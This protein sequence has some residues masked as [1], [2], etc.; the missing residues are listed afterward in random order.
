MT[1]KISSASNQFSL[2]VPAHRFRQGGRDVYFFALD[3]GT[4]DGLLPQ[5]VDDSVVRDANRRLTPSHAQSIQRYLDK[6]DDWVLGALL[7]GIARDA[8]E[9]EPYSGEQADQDGQ[10]ENPF[11][12]F[13]ELRV[14]TNR[15]NT[16]RIFD[17]QHRRR[18]IQEVLADLSNEHDNRSHDKLDA[19]RK[20]SMTIVLYVE[21]DIRTLRQ[22][23]VDASNTKR[24]E[25]NTVTRF[26]QRDAFNRVAVR[27]A[28]RSYLFRGRVEMERSSVS[29][30]SQNLMAINQ[31]AATL[32]STAVGYG[33]RVSRDLNEFYMQNLD[34][35]YSRCHVW[36]DEFMPAAREEYSGLL[37][38]QI[39]NSE[40]PQLRASTFA[41]SVTFFRVLASCYSR[42]MKEN[43]SWKPLADFISNASL[44]P[45]SEH[46]L[47]V[48]AGLVEPGGTSLISRRQEVAST[49][50]HIISA[51]ET[52][53]CMKCGRKYINCKC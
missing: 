9:F 6:Q 12:N 1:L 18:A 41:Y 15:V 46:G 38:G 49:V 10:I 13:G 53:A 7:L 43:E 31:L 5:R 36:S 16:M 8:V 48:E 20:A 4:L 30:T 11:P 44:S 42:W 34:E 40:I 37:S 14:R 27:L 19:L 23:F 47:L 21:E 29:R 35:L 51:I 17:G 52:E 39:D 2:R 25:G 28:D 24:I 33:R 32:K 26:D 45:R 22:M 3:L 50:E